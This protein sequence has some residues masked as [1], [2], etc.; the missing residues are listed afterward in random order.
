MFKKSVKIE[1]LLTSP[2]SI[3]SLQFAI[4][5]LQSLHSSAG[6]NKFERFISKIDIAW[7]NTSW[8]VHCN[9]ALDCPK[10]TQSLKSQ[11]PQGFSG[12]LDIGH[13]VQNL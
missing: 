13:I 1:C 8:N 10:I 6:K 11:A 9:V 3:A 12:C 5:R 4:F 2:H 7:F